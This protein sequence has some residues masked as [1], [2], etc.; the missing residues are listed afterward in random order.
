[1]RIQSIDIFRADG[2]WRPFS[3]LRLRTDSGLVGWSEFAE[4]AWAPGLADA[5]IAL[6]GQV[7]GSDPRAWAKLSADLH[8]LTQ[9]TAG[10]VSHQ[11]VAA[12]E[13][14]C[15]DLAA[16][17]LGVPVYQLFGGP[18]RREL[19]CYGSHWGSFR[20]RDAAFFKDVIGCAPVASLDDFRAIGHEAVQRGFCTVKTN[21]VGFSEEGRPV[22]LNPGFAPGL[23]HGRRLDARTLA[24][25][26]AQCRALRDGLG[27]DRGLMLDVNFSL[28]PG[29]LRQLGRSLGD[30]GLTWLE[31]DLA[32]PEAL[33]AV[34]AAVPVPIASLESLHGRR[35]Y[36]PYFEAGAVDVAVI[37]VPWN[38]LGEAL[39]IAALAESHE[40]NV[41]PHNF[42]GPLADLMSAHF[43]A[44][45]PN[46]EIMETEADDVPWK[47][48]LLTQAPDRGDGRFGLPQSPGWGADPDE[49]ALA[50]HPWPRA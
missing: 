35:A 39:R 17:S 50:R 6:G 33:A 3:F 15:L 5:I 7:L 28:H 45:V 13:N 11:A 10:G 20:V 34:R 8:A 9:F 30:V 4:S 23:E 36:R 25:I 43:C 1:M 31:A 2:G 21:P 14:A 38:G 49:Q 12:I 47:Y 48:A 19:D 41:A 26:V 32:S 46:L 37:D 22:L 27:A 44:V 16:K 29:A 18:L 40:V 24:G 42:Y